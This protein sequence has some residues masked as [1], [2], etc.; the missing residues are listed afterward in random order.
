M[1]NCHGC[2]WLDEGK[3]QPNG[4]DTAAWWSEAKRR[5]I[6]YVGQT[7][8]AANATRKVTGKHAGKVKAPKRPERAVCQGWPPGTDDGGLRGSKEKG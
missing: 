1:M 5:A 4:A 7:W 2:K 6:E 8:S 3:R